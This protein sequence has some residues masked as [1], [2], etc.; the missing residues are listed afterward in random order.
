MEETHSAFSPRTVEQQTAHYL[1]PST[2]EDAAHALEREMVGDLQSY[3]MPADYHA[4]L[5]RVWL[6][7][8][9]Q[10]HTVEQRAAQPSLAQ[11]RIIDLARWR[12]YHWQPQ[13]FATAPGQIRLAQYVGV[14]TI[15][16]ACALVLGR[17]IY[18]FARHKTP[19]QAPLPAAQ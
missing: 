16:M 10:Q 9:A 14:A 17:L 1:L 2:N 7:F 6:R 8:L 11:T 13:K 3:Y 18:M 4:S 15:I 5:Q 12:K 19:G